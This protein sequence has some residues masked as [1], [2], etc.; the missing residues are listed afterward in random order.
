MQS[1][2]L[3]STC[4]CGYNLASGLCRW[5]RRTGTFGLGGVGGEGGDF[6]ARKIYPIPECAIV[7]IGIQTHSNCTKNKLV[8]KLPCGGKFFVGV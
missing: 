7:E 6:L 5:H 2:L 3:Q 1:E 8:H 4:S